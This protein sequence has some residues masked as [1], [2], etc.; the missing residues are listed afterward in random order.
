M[1]VSGE[2]KNKAWKSYHEKPFN[3]EFVW[4]RNSSSVTDKVSEAP[5]LID[6]DLIRESISKMM[7]GKAAGSSGVES[8][9]VEAAGEAGVA[10]SL[11]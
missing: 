9:M 7:N 8:E 11:T 5:S 6:R 10:L 1:A 2:D 4:D 3:T